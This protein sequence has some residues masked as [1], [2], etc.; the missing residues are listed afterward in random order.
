MHGVIRHPVDPFGMADVDFAQAPRGLAD[1]LAALIKR[2]AYQTPCDC[3][4]ASSRATCQSLE[5]P[6]GVSVPS[7][8]ARSLST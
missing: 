4:H 3:S 2:K 7:G 1:T 6:F 8:S 5:L